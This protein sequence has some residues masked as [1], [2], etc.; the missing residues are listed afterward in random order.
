MSKHRRKS[1]AP[2]RFKQ[3]A[4][5]TLIELLLYIALVSVLLT[6]SISFTW[7]VIYGRVK[8]HVQQE[9]SQNLRL[10]S[11]RINY[12]LRNAQKINSVSAT[13]LCLESADTARNPTRIY[14][15]N[16]QLWIGWGGGGT[17]CAT[18]TN[19]EPLT[20]KEVS[21]T[22]LNFTNLSTGTLSS[23]HIRYN[24]TI[25]SVNPQNRVEWEMSRSLAGSAELRVPGN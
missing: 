18:T 8:S 24:V 4:G 25:E 10:V 16:G 7:N 17:T 5:F 19:A 23:Q 15:N 1:L 6:A 13:S 2:H 20:S 3:E 9:V 22:A 21:V 14:L 12:E 11:Q